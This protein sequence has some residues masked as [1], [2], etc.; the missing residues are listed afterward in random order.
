VEGSKR[1]LE[2]ARKAA[3]KTVLT[4][5][6]ISAYPGSRSNYGQAKLEIEK[7]ALAQ[8]GLVVRPGLIWGGRNLGMHGKLLQQ[9]S[10][11]KPVPLL[12]GSAC[13]QHLVHVE[14]L[15]RIIEG[16][17]SGRIPNPEQPVVIAHPKPWPLRD[18]LTAMAPAKKL[19]FIPVPWWFVWLAIK[20]AETLGLK[21]GFKSDGVISLVY[22]DKNPDLKWPEKWREP[23]RDYCRG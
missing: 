15:C 10:R 23:L 12:T 19:T 16:L 4:V 17:L 21:P 22:Q 2:Q 7:A 14:D 20:T 1:V 3:V 13:I 9:A 6:S 11:G 5:S 8:G 18:L